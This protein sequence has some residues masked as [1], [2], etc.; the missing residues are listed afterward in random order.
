MLAVLASGAVLFA[1]GSSDEEEPTAEDQ[2]RSVLAQNLTSADRTQTECETTVSDGYVERV[3]GDLEGC[4]EFV[5]DPDEE[6]A[7]P[8][9]LEFEAIDVN[10]SEASVQVE[11]RSGALQGVGGGLEVVEDPERGWLLDRFDGDFARTSA[12]ASLRGQLKPTTSLCVEDGLFGPGADD[13]DAKDLYV[14]LSRGDQRA[15]RAVAQVIEQ[16]ADAVGA[17]STAQ[18]EQGEDIDPSNFDREE[19]D[20]A[21]ERGL[22]EEQGLGE[23]LASCV[24]DRLGETLSDKEA[25]KVVERSQDGKPPPR[26]I[27]AKFDRAGAQCASQQQRGGGR[28]A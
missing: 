20:R 28:R 25:I 1:C 18:N 12:I 5:E 9:D 23:G 16:C 19:F 4:K 22:V 15:T 6:L 2:I 11:I 27:R 17:P 21:L 24:V 26:K 13:R 3:Y 10:G 8:D 7:E 14:G